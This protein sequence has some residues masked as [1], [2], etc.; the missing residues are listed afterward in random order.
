MKTERSR[1]PL[2]QG[3]RDRLSG[4]REK[5]PNKKGKSKLLKRPVKEEKK[6]G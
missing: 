2:I 1:V 6:D 4:K 5:P 3:K